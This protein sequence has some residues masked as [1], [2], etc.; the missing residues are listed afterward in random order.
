MSTDAPGG[1][2]TPAE[3]AT[4]VSDNE[5]TMKVRAELLATKGL[6]SNGIRVKTEN[7]VVHLDGKV[8]SDSEKLT[9]LN[10]T[11]SGRCPIRLGWATGGEIAHCLDLR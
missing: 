4:R 9:A 3:P 2:V 5:I 8:Q 10:A 1:R 11:R 6:K 7:G